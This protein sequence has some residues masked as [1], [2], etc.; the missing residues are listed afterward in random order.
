MTK[1]DAIVRALA[2][3]LMHEFKT[4][5]GT[6]FI[7]AVMIVKTIELLFDCN[8]EWAGN[9]RVTITVTPKFKD[10]EFVKGITIN[11]TSEHINTI[12]QLKSASESTRK[13]VME[14]R[15]FHKIADKLGIKSFILKHYYHV[16][17]LSKH[18][19]G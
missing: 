1:E 9:S 16:Q 10:G 13:I 2:S 12:P 19:S 4:I 6:V 14:Y 3:S 8:I 18:S 11:E 5:S 15:A 17:N 7:P